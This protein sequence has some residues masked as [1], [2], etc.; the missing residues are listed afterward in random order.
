MIDFHRIC[1]EEYIFAMAEGREV[2]SEYV[3]KNAYARYEEA[4][5]HC[6][7]VKNSIKSEIAL[8]SKVVPNV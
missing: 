5:R 4:I 1:M 8:A 3:K 6:N 2:D 7:M